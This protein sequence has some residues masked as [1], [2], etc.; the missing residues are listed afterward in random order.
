MSL[1][2]SKKTK[3]HSTWSAV[4]FLGTKWAL[5]LTQPYNIKNGF[6]GL[7]LSSLRNYSY[8]RQGASGRLVQRA[9]LEEKNCRFLVTPSCDANAQLEAGKNVS[10]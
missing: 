8:E 1:K 5:I 10:T 6:L 3:K 7:I 2:D 9:L 4:D